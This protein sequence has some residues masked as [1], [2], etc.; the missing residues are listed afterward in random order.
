MVFAEIKAVGVKMNVATFNGYNALKREGGLEDE[1]V[2]DGC[3]LGSANSP[4][5]QPPA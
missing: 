5:L 2:E 1:E 4:L 3:K